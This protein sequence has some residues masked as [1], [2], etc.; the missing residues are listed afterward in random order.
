M[1]AAVGVAVSRAQS[2]E[3]GTICEVAVT[4]GDGLVPRKLG[5]QVNTWPVA[6]G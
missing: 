5:W 6:F 4:E 2:H 3:F 1:R